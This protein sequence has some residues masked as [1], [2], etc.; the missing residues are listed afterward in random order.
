MKKL[1]NMIVVMLTVVIFVGCSYSSKDNVELDYCKDIYKSL[2]KVSSSF[3][4]IR[5]CYDKNED[6]VEFRFDLKSKREV[7]EKKI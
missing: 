6:V 7:D 2:N 1:L 5:I 3:K 4:C